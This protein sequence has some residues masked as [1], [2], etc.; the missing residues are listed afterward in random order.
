MAILNS[1]DISDYGSHY[2][3]Q[4]RGAQNVDQDAMQENNEIAFKLAIQDGLKEE[5]GLL[6]QISI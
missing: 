1:K 5:F 2:V 6:C 3:N 4:V